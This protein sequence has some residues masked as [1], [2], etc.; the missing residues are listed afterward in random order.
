MR[1]DTV[2]SRN[3]ED[4]ENIEFDIPDVDIPQDIDFSL[5]EVDLP[6]VDLDIHDIDMKLPSN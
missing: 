1:N 3:I 5:P 2:D 6:D 4:I